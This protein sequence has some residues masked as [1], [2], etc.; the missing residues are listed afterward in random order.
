MGLPALEL[1]GHWVELGLS[2]ETKLLPIDIMWGW[3]VSGGLMSWTRP[4]HLGAS[5]PIP[6]RST[7]T[8]P[9]TQ[10]TRK[11]KKLKKHNKTKT[12]TK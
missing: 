2:V 6:G 7:K 1:A 12:K 5:D 11:G 4:S 10:L 3:D 8:L 9:A